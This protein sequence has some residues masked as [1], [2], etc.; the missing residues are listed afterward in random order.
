MI[1]DIYFAEVEAKVMATTKVMKVS[2]TQ[3]VIVNNN[4][5]NESIGKFKFYSVVDNYESILSGIFKKVARS[6]CDSFCHQIGSKYCTLN[7]EVIK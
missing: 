5:E 3:N 2:S 4:I 1:K 7:V 6:A